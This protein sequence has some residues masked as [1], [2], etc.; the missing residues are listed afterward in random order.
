MVIEPF[1]RTTASMRETASR[2]SKPSLRARAALVAAACNFFSLRFSP[3]KSLR[4]RALSVFPDLVVDARSLA[5]A[6]VVRPVLQ[7][8]TFVV[9]AAASS[10]DSV[11]E[12]DVSSSPR[13]SSR[14]ARSSAR[15]SATAKPSA[16]TSSPSLSPASSSLEARTANMRRLGVRLACFCSRTTKFN[17][18]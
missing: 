5:L 6:S 3:G 2:A 16:V 17:K 10:S 15:A 18:K 8:H 14:R 12:E 11:D 4:T 1:S 13:A 7:R 9:V